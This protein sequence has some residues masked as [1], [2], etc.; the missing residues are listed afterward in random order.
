MK[1][2]KNEPLSQLALGLKKHKLDE[3]KD[4]TPTPLS[5][6][7]TLS[8]PTP[9]LEMMTFT[10]PITHSKGKGK[11]GKRVWEDLAVALGQAYNVITDDELRGLLSILSHELVSH[12][13]YKFVQVFY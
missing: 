13:I 9:S 5:L 7:G 11:V 6:V 1:S 8:S 12:H 10:P 2:L 4:E 3:G